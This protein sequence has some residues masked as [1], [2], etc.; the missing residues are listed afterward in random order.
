[1]S[2]LETQ[3]S[4]ELVPR[5]MERLLAEAEA[6]AARF[7]Q[8]TWLN[9]PDIKRLP[10]RSDEAALACVGGSF[11][12]IPHIRA[13]DRDVAASVRLL[14]RLAH[15]GVTDALIVTGDRIRQDEPADHPRTLDLLRAAAA[16]PIQLWAA[17]DPY[18]GE[19]KGELEYA[20]AKIEAGAV[21]LF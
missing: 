6:V 13:R 3:L 21:G 16:T 20:Q 1:M 2:A 7:P 12:V 4:I 11:R 17:F 9:I 8:M 10:V 18:R 19:L 14:E 15:A 5:S